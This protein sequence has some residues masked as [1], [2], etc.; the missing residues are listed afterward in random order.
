MSI[1]LP[2]SI[3]GKIMSYIDPNTFCINTIQILQLMVIEL[4]NDKSLE[5][6]KQ[7]WNNYC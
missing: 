5:H 1:I 7:I 2:K 6:R 3:I 4:H